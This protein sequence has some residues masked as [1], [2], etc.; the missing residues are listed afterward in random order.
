[1][2]TTV[3]VS[4]QEQAFKIF[5]ALPGN[6]FCADCPAPSP[7]WASVNLG[8]FVCHKC[9]G[10]HRSIGLHITRIKSMKL[11]SWTLKQLYLMN[12]VNNQ[13]ANLYWEALRPADRERP[14]QDTT[15]GALKAFIYDKYVHK[16]FVNPEGRPPLEPIMEKLNQEN[17]NDDETK[18]QFF[19]RK[20]KELEAEIQQKAL[21]ASIENPKAMI[22]SAKSDKERIISSGLRQVKPFTAETPRHSNSHRK[23]FERQGSDD[24][25]TVLSAP[26]DLK[27]EKEKPS[28]LPSDKPYDM[29]AGND[30]SL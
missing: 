2:D 14:H 10:V 22:A 28:A 17:K 7:D 12:Y 24:E 15:H 21:Q 1:M 11:D 4:L 13:E 30:E 8:V 5:L 27:P 18:E 6:Q 23:T 3:S 20:L 19:Q 26:K 25:F 29:F 16:K 9:S